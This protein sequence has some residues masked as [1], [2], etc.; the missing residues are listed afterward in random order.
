MV[1]NSQGEIRK[2]Y[3]PFR[4]LAHATD[5]SVY[6]DE[7]LTNEHNELFYMVNGLPIIHHHFRI[8]INF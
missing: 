6:I 1:I 5:L 3:T 7:V 4:V 2:L 8:N